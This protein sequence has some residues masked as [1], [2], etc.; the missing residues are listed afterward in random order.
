MVSLSAPRSPPRAL[1][2]LGWDPRPRLRIIPR[3]RESFPPWRGGEDVRRSSFDAWATCTGSAK[4]DVAHAGLRF[5]P[6][7]YEINSL[8]ALDHPVARCVGSQVET[9]TVAPVPSGDAGCPALRVKHPR[10]SS[11]DSAL[12]LDSKREPA[13]APVSTVPPRRAGSGGEGT[14]ARGWVMTGTLEQIAEVVP[15]SNDTTSTRRPTSI[16]APDDATSTLPARP[17]TMQGVVGAADVW[18]RVFRELDRVVDIPCP[19]LLTGPHGSGKHTCARALHRSGAPDQPFVVVDVAA[20]ALRSGDARAHRVAIDS[21]PERWLELAG[22]GTLFVS[23]LTRLPPSAQLVLG[24]ALGQAFQRPDACR[25]IVASELSVEQLRAHPSVRQ[26]FFY[27]VSVLSCAVPPLRERGDDI[28]ELAREFLHATPRPAVSVDAAPRPR[29]GR[30][31]PFSPAA[32]QLLLSYPWPGN[33]AELRNAVEHAA[34]L[35]RGRTIRPADLPNHLRALTAPPHLSLELPLE[36]MDLRR[37][38]DALE[39]RFLQEALDRTSWNK[40]QAARLLG[41]NRTTLVEM[42][43]RKRLRRPAAQD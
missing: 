24:E 16:R 37:T 1:A 30:A 8:R 19:V 27:R 21:S 38:L 36:G 15:P 31:R 3:S 41:L 34:A 42:L 28:L 11:S 17:R 6:V 18:L 40:Q 2:P 35:A 22:S 13:R 20:S 9:V 12:L 26:D 43:K 5:P 33:V 32:E 29:T 10:T 4:H 14:S 39:S 23:E 7:S 25:L